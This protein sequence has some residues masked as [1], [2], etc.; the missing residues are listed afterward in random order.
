MDTFVQYLESREHCDYCTLED[1][2]VFSRIVELFSLLHEHSP[3]QD[4]LTKVRKPK[5]AY[6]NLLDGFISL[7]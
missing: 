4:D 7:E 1:I 5:T 6:M 3:D 2:E